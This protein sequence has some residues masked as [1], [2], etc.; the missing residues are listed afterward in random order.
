MSASLDSLRAQKGQ[1][2][3]YDMTDG[4][5]ASVKRD[6]VRVAGRRPTRTTTTT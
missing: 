3:E 2:A 1:T 5:V 6:G 4:F